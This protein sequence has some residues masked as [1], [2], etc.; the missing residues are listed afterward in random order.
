[1]VVTT[2]I[3]STMSGVRVTTK[4]VDTP[5]QSVGTIPDN[6]VPAVVGWVRC[7]GS[8]WTLYWVV[9]GCFILFLCKCWFDSCRQDQLIL[10]VRL[11]DTEW[12]K[13]LRLQSLSRALAERKQF[14]LWLAFFAVTNTSEVKELKGWWSQKNPCVTFVSFETRPLEDGTQ[15]IGEVMCGENENK[16][17]SEQIQKQQVMDHLLPSPTN[18]TN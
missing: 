1:M 7:W 16:S 15:A 17:K 6:E 14:E 9:V 5:T 8:G 13:I 18:Q 4:K 10:L 3:T 11:C 2:I 12:F